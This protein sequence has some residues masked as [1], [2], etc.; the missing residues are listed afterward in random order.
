MIAC[1]AATHQQQEQT[2][3][4]KE[5]QQGHQVPASSAVSKESVDPEVLAY[6]QHQ[7]T[8]AR[9]SLAEEAR[10]LVAYGK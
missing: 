7:A 6:Q 8:A 3:Q 10:T 2:E 1:Y 9:M 4:P 5:Q